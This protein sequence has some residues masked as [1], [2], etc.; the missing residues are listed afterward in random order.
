[1]NDSLSQIQT[2]RLRKL[3][4][5]SPNLPKTKR[6]RKPVR[7]ITGAQRRLLGEIADY[8]QRHG[9]SPT[10][11]ELADA[12]SITPPA[13]HDQ[14]SQL[15]RKKYV[16]REPRKNRG[17][18]ILRMPEDSEPLT[19]GGELVDFVAVPLLGTVAA[20]SPVLA[21]ENVIGQVLLPAEIAAQAP[22]FALTVSGDS[23]KGA[24][25]VD[26]DVVIVRQQP[27]ARDGDIVVALVDGEA[28]VK[29]LSMRESKIELRPSNSKYRPISIGPNT[30]LRIVGKVVGVRR[31][32]RA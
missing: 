27:L 16:R 11:Q 6:G 5:M 4:N 22:C 12:L 2:G 20:G 7:T 30:D 13:V 8:I 15:V 17:L 32:W 26:G 3:A 21:E 14:V 24:G 23:M 19:T 9:F 31:Q 10:H 18:S 28:T 29:R 25:I 1:M